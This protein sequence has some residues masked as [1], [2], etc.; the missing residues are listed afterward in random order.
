MNDR[1]SQRYAAAVLL[2][3]ALFGAGTPFAKLLVG[4][5]TPWMLAGLLYGGSGA[6]LGIIVL[7]RRLSP[8]QQREAPLRRADTPWLAATILA[9][10]IAA[11]VLLLW[12]LQGTA[13]STA[14]LLLNLEGV[15]TAALAAM[16]FHEAVGKR[17]WTAAA[18]MLAA[19]GLLAY[20]PGAA[21]SLSPHALAIMGACLLWALDNNLTCR[22]SGGDP[23]AIGAIKGLAGGGINIGL[24]LLTG[25]LLPAVGQIVAAMTLGLFSYGVSV[26]LFVYGLR[27]LG[28]ARTSAH[29]STAPFF[30]AAL[31]IA[32]LAEPLSAI[33]AAAAALM[34]GATL[35]ALTER[36]AHEHRH[37]YL[38]HTHRHTH[39]DAHHQHEHT[40]DEGDAPHAHW[41]VHW[42][43]RHHHPHLP[44]IHHRHSH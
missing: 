18:L 39:D 12:G 2:A 33:L 28:S 30:G 8:K 38:A 21:F 22:I 16:G 37:E 40:G 6:G 44:D 19:S 35:L 29:F 14:S 24:A 3:A 17:I 36:H 1:P 4:H 41:H 34:F 9:G 26:V 43:M 25:A 27:H 20:D 13:A 5:L 42:S 11:P 31:S 10:G 7:L 32:L 15:L 23:L